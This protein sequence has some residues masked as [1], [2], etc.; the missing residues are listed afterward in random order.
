MQ[1]WQEIL[2]Q[3]QTRAQAADTLLAEARMAAHDTIA[4]PW[5]DIGL[6]RASG[7]EAPGFL[8]NL[9]TN[10]VANL[11][12]GGVRRAAFCTPKGRMLADFLIWR[13]NED[14][15]LQCAADVHGAMLKKLSMYV[16]R[17]KVKLTDASS[18]HAVIG[19]AGPGANRI[20]ADVGCTL[21]APLA[22]EKFTHGQ[23]LGLEL[24]RY[25]IIVAAGFVT[26][27]WPEIAKRA[28]IVGTPAW[29]WTEITAGIPRIVA[30]T[31]EQFVPQM[32]NFDRVA[33]ISFKKGCYPGQ[34]IVARTH[35]LGKI[36]RRMIRAHLANG[37][38]A[39]GTTIHAP[40]TGE[41][42]CGIVV[43]TAPSPEG[44]LDLLASVQTS[45]IEAGVLHIGTPEGPHLRLLPLPY[46]ME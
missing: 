2:N 41:Q 28:R 14:F 25:Q 45:C 44:G 29:R 7:E 33:G 46:P 12:E 35:Y 26:E 9:F 18:T 19:L 38:A 24:N 1:S 20:A 16:L 10:D 22:T 5:L 36:K 11:P 40:E 23:F 6:I 4:S 42:A 3:L 8:H 21:P 17:S 13:D 27:I 30:A 31:Q 39:P 15:L 37:A 43:S 34:E 32:V